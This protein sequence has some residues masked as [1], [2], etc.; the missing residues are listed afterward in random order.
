[1]QRLLAERACERLIVDFVHRLDL[2]EPASV[3]EPFAEAGTWEWPPPGDGGRV[4]R[5][6]NRWAVPPVT[7]VTATAWPQPLL[8]PLKAAGKVAGSSSH[9]YGGKPV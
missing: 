9:P 5:C 2:G 6:A 4:R 7:L 1:M 3:A 8:R